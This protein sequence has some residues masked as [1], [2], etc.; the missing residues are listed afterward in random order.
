VNFSEEVTRLLVDGA[1]QLMATA[2]TTGSGSGQPT[3][4]ITALPG[5]S[6]VASATTDTFARADVYNVQNALP[7]RF[8]ANAQWCAGL[9][10]IN[11][12]SQ[13]ETTAGARLFPELSDGRLLNKPINELS[14]M[15]SVINATQDN[16][17]LLYGDFS[18]LV[19]VDRIGST[20]ELIPNLVG[21][22]RRPTG[23]RGLFL[24]FRT[25]S[26]SLVD[27]AFRCLNVT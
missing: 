14:N 1:D 19:I 10:I 2:Y 13:F 17:I 25:G 4:I 12:M 26:D 24:W 9:P 6:L 3:G 8:S 11:T 15:D 5:G 16:K 21:A 7:P 23:Q 27:N 18:N 20:V 22:N